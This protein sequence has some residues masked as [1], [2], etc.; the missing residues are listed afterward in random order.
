MGAALSLFITLLWSGCHTTG[1]QHFPRIINEPMPIA[2]SVRREFGTV[3]VLPV[4]MTT[5]VQFRLPVRRAEIFYQVAGNT[6]HGMVET[7]EWR[8]SVGTLFGRDDDLE[9]W[10]KDD[11]GADGATLG[12]IT[13]VS[14]ATGAVGAAVTGVPEER[15]QRCQETLLAAS[16]QEPIDV[17]IDHHL[18]R[19]V[20]RQR[21]TN[22]HLLPETELANVRKKDAG[23]DFSAFASQGLDSILDIRVTQLGFEFRRGANPEL[24][25]APEVAVYVI[26]VRD[27]TVLHSTFLKYR[28]Q[29]RPFTGW[30]ERDAKPF[31]REMARAEQQFAESILDLYLG[32]NSNR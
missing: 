14:L 11:M 25:L 7:M 6:W 8:S 26:R 28:G 3:G 4:A 12:F 20:D 30:A 17:G 31:R 9:R 29:R 18:A 19:A 32:R 10:D 2:E 15:A 13:L 1:D 21:L 24:A 5:N 27:G 22:V 16:H 23:L